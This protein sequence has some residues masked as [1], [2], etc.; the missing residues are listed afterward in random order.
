MC[1]Y[2]LHVSEYIQYGMDAH[3]EG[4]NRARTPDLIPTR[5]YPT[6]D[7]VFESRLQLPAT[8][9]SRDANSRRPGR[10]LGV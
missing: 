7:S 6:G 8:D 2:L 9:V 4:L 3:A 1:I 5:G 10:G